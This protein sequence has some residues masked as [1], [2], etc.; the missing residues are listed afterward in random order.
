MPTQQQ[1]VL[2]NFL[3]QAGIKPDALTGKQNS[4]TDT[5]PA[6]RLTYSDPVDPLTSSYFTQTG[7]GAGE[8]SASLGAGGGM[9][10]YSF[11]GSGLFNDMWDVSKPG[12]YG[13][14]M[15]MPWIKQSPGAEGVGDIAIDPQGLHDW[16]GQENL[17]LME[18]F[19]TPGSGQSARWVQDKEGNIVGTP[20]GV[21]YHDPNFALAGAIAAS[22]ATAGVGAGPVVAGAVGGG[23]G[24]AG[25]GASLTDILKG[26]AIG[27]ASGYAGQAAGAAGLGKLG[28]TIA[29]SLTSS[30]LKGGSVKSAL[31]GILLKTV[32][33]Q[34]NTGNSVSDMLARQL[35]GSKL[36]QVLVPKKG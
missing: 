32:L 17:S 15:A 30:A 6:K 27:G 13:D 3:R 10:F 5:A 25:G 26:A 24:A 18:G 31:S 33:G 34:V 22:I 20:Q 1:I 8:N 35:I 23:V 11:A 29:S 19:N 21:N 36:K 14:L 28:S 9:D 12:K 7:S 16:L 2:A 4:T